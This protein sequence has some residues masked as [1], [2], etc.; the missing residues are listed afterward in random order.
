MLD[1]EMNNA[2][3]AS[4]VDE[5]KAK[6]QEAKEQE[7]LA[8]INKKIEDPEI[9]AIYDRCT[10]L[11]YNTSTVLREINAYEQIKWEKNQALKSLMEVSLD[12]WRCIPSTILKERN[13]Y[14]EILKFEDIEW[15]EIVQFFLK[16]WNKASECVEDYEAFIELKESPDSIL[17]DLKL[18]YI[19]NYKENNTEY[20]TSRPI[21]FLVSEYFEKIQWFWDDY[22]DY[23]KNLIKETPS[24]HYIDVYQNTAI[25]YMRRN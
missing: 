4:R 17:K 8:I 13:S 20:D 1:L 21:D 14:G 6:E 24:I 11:W 12:A 10:K 22:I 15:N 2:V 7:M 25:E 9:K 5:Q 23:A 16:R 18:A 3:D 19:R